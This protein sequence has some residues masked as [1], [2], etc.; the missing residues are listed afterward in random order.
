MMGAAAV[1]MMGG[2]MMGATIT[3]ALLQT[4]PLVMSGRDL[5]DE[6]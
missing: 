4:L 2:A 5:R 3:I 1:A 6:G